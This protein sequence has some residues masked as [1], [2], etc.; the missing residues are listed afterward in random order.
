MRALLN[1]VGTSILSHWKDESQEL[2]DASHRRV[3]AGIAR[4]PRDDRGLGAELSS[5]VS[6]ADQEEIAPGDRLYFLVSDTREGRFVGGVLNDVVR[7]WGYRPANV[8]VIK[9]LQGTDPQAFE[10]GLRELVRTI[11]AL[12]R[13]PCKRRR[14]G[15][16]QRHRR[17]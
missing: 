1:T 12:Y 15:P 5:I 16:A 10:R 13:T 8:E 4:L 9:N 11:S 17:L 6:I 3:L 7:A 14:T 2:S